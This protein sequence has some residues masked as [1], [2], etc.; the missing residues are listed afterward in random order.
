[1]KPKVYNE[2]EIFKYTF[3]ELNV[4]LKCPVRLIKLNTI[5]NTKLM[6]FNLN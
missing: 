2:K 1:M 4:S 5:D 6:L 3:I